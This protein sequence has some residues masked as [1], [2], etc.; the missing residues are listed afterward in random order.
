MTVKK[1]GMTKTCWDSFRGL[2]FLKEPSKNNRIFYRKIGCLFDMSALSI[3][4]LNSDKIENTFFTLPPPPQVFTEHTEGLVGGR[5][6]LLKV[7]GTPQPT[8]G[9]CTGKEKTIPKKKRDGLKLMLRDWG[10]QTPTHLGGIRRKEKH[11]SK[12]YWTGATQVVGW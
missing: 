3:K 2:N 10:P 6:H 12:K 1:P 4:K 11:N 8:G 7:G 9:G 5:T